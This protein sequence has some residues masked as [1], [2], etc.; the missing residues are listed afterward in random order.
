MADITMTVYGPGRTLATGANYT[1][2]KTAAT[3]SNVYYI[4]NDGNVRLA[5]AAGTTSNMTIETPG[6]G[7]DGLAITDNVI[8]LD[9]KVRI[10]GPFPPQNYNDAQGRLKVTVSANADLF[11]FR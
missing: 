9:T 1:D 3:S 6:T 2:N 5:A 4:P 7:P 11:A 10:F 8:A